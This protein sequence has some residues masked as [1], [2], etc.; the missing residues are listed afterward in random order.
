MALA[1]LTLPVGSRSSTRF[2]KRSGVL[3]QR[4][5]SFADGDAAAR[6]NSRA[7]GSREWILMAALNRT[8]FRKR[9]RLV[10][11]IIASLLAGDL[12]H[13]QPASA[14]NEELGLKVP[15]GFTVTRFAGDEHAHDIFCMTIDALGRVVVSG[16]GYVK[17]LIDSNND[18]VADQV[19]TFVD[20]PA[21]GAQGMFFHGR[22]L[23]LAGGEGLIR[24]R[25]RD[26]DDKADGPPDVFLRI[27]AG[28][29]HDL[30]AIRRGPDG[31]WY[32]IAGNTSGVNESYAATETSPVKKPHAGVILRMKPDLSQGEVFAH[33]F[34]NAYDFDFNSTGEVFAFDSD[35]ENVMSLPWYQPTKLFHVLQGGHQGWVSN[36]WIRPDYFFD[37][38]PVVAEFGR[39]SPT[40]VSSYQHTAFPLKY[41]GALFVQD[42]TF[43]RIYAVPLSQDGSTWKGKPEEFVSAVGQHGFAPTDM[44]V[45][46]NGELYV[47]VGGRGT[48]GGVYCI[49][50]IAKNPNSAAWPIAN[51][52]PTSTAEKLELCLK[53]PQPLSAWSRRYWEP[54]AKEL[55]SEQFIKAALDRKRPV[56]ER[57]RAIEILT[58]KH[59]GFSGDV[60]A[61]L[62]MDE[63]PVVRAR[64]AWSLGRTQTESPNSRTL[65]PFFKDQDPMVGRAA[66]EA[67]QSGTPAQ[68]DDF[69]NLLSQQL[70]QK[71]RYLRQ[72]A[73]KVLVKVKPDSVHRMAQV[74]YQKGWEAS[75]PIAASYALRGDGY[76]AYAVDIALRILK[77]KNSDEL[78]VEAARLLQIGLGDVAPTGDKLDGV[79]TG[80][81]PRIDLKP[82]AAAITK[83]GRDLATIYPTKVA[84]V[85]REIERV[86]AMIQPQIPGL[87]DQ[88]L[89]GISTDTHP[90]DDIHRLIV[91]ARIPGAR[92]VEQRQFIAQALLNLDPK[93]QTH[94]LQQDSHWGDHILE[95]FTAHAEFDPQLP[96]AL[97]DNPSFGLPGH[98]LFVPVLEQNY[99]ERIADVFYKQVKS[100][101]N[102][103]WSQELVFILAATG[104]KEAMKMI[105]EKFDD[106]S[107]RYAVLACFAVQPE[108]VDRPL[109][110]EGLRTGNIDSMLVCI[111]ALQILKSSSDPA[112]NVVLAKTLRKLGD[113]GE[114]RQ[115]R[116][117][118]VELLRRNLN[119]RDA[120]KL[121]QD[122]LAQ[123]EAIS[124]WVTLIQE[125]FPSEFAASEQAAAENVAQLKARL[126]VID[127]TKGDA[128]KG[129]KLFQ[130]RSCIQ[131]HGKSG[132]LG[133]DLTGVAG[134]F[135]RDDL[136]TAIVFPNQDI[137]PR[138]QGVQI[139]TTQGQVRSG[140]IVYEGIDG[141]VIRDANNHTYRIEAEEI[142]ERLPMTSSLMPAGLL[143]GLTDQDYADMYSYLRS[144]GTKST[145]ESGA[146]S[147]DSSR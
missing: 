38:A 114:E 49:R 58:E 101:P 86:F 6:R 56:A 17:I 137:S 138:Y 80:Y 31:W 76:S 145:A 55:S 75:V 67:I 113:T 108:E 122:G 79:F 142:D 53:A 62:A 14:V 32:L 82:H 25:D 73:T 64:A 24:Y 65:E 36:N 98:I 107:L 5:F 52:A 135:S 40:G 89:S 85:D 109:F 132:A 66:V 26:G 70:P 42:W 13:A 41:H 15:S 84:I 27:N 48:R 63:S 129:E 143:Q 95:M 78:K 37:A 124:Q 71:D 146:G 8:G 106:L 68:L 131:C 28:N 97:L 34:R 104:E 139:V 33:G 115:A 90:V 59:N 94:K 105:R 130:S 2:R 118:T 29:E 121:G 50:P 4:K 111:E 81:A 23:L 18:G 10:A 134:R 9:Y 117:Q 45:G 1:G 46:V 44:E 126:D 3:G 99:T 30:H 11:I 12:V 141:L 119:V 123:Q 88:I 69:T 91:T 127:W 92:T 22:D 93:I 60:A 74:A 103:P 7:N 102:F 125:R 120:Y 144:L 96:L 72:A 77:G 112:E 147:S 47:S 100:N 20:G 43:G 16:P 136:F 57:V 61:Q 110:V 19:K 140:L 51:G 83:L 133:P 35:G 54:V 128:L 87:L 116:D 39:G 21:S